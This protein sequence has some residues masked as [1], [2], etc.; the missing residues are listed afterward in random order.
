MWWYFFT[1]LKI[2]ADEEDVRVCKVWEGE[3]GRGGDGQDRRG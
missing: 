2:G 1:V 3:W